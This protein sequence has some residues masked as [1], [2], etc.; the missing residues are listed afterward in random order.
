M[1]WVLQEWRCFNKTLAS[2]SH[3]VKIY[4][5]FVDYLL[6]VPEPQKYTD[7]QAGS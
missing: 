3:K 5:V 2:G 6:R 7:Y 4:R 1:T